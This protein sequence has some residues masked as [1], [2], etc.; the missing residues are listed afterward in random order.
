MGKQ[1][2]I[3]WVWKDGQALAE[4]PSRK[5]TKAWPCRAV[6]GVMRVQWWRW[7]CCPQCSWVWKWR[8]REVRLL[9]KGFA[10]CEGGHDQNQGLP[11][12]A[13]APFTAPATAFFT[14]VLILFKEMTTDHV[15]WSDAFGVCACGCGCGYKFAAN[16][17][18]S[19][20]CVSQISI[21]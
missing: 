16:E 13:F 5:G 14:H 20:C 10:A 7:L 19:G 21:S 8:A 6:G 17:C 18:G 1:H 15:F 3:C 4:G 12:Q 2:H 9:V 11:T